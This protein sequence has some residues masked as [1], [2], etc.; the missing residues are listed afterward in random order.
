M[1]LAE[2]RSK[3]QGGGDLRDIIA[4]EIDVR[5]YPPPGSEQHKILHLDRFHGRT[6]RQVNLHVNIEK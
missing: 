5:L 3:P 2:L 4:R 6:H 1:Q